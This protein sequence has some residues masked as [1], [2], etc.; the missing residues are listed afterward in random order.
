MSHIIRCITKRVQFGMGTND[1]LHF[2]DCE[3]SL[4]E[5]LAQ[6]STVG[7]LFSYITET[8]SSTTSDVLHRLFE[9]LK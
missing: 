7:E 5:T 6:V 2:Q 1:Q 9:S 4:L 3:G 8:N